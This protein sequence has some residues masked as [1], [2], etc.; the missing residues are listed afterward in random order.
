[1][2]KLTSFNE[3]EKVEHPVWKILNK[4]KYVEE[5]YTQ[6]EEMYD[7]IQGIVHLCGNVTK[8][9]NSIPAMKMFYDMWNEYSSETFR[10]L[11]SLVHNTTQR[12]TSFDEDDHTKL[13]VVDFGIRAEGGFTIKYSNGCT[14]SLCKEQ[15]IA[16]LNQE[17]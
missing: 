6:A 16:K 10:I 2:Q 12:L 4:E 9:G 15:L 14:S 7:F 13:K 17:K 11:E 5:F 8:D 3:F 1:M